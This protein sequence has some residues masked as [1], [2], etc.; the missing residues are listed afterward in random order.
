[1]IKT[2]T[3]ALKLNPIDELHHKAMELAD[4]AYYAKR[5]H[6]D[7][8]TAQTAYQEAFRY[9]EAAAML[10]VN[11]YEYEPSRSVL[12]RSAASLL[13]QLPK[14]TLE[15]YKNIE[16]MAAYGLAGKPNPAIANELREVLETI[17]NAPYAVLFPSENPTLFEKEGSFT[18]IN[19]KTKQF[20]FLTSEEEVI[21]GSFG[22]KVEIQ[23][24]GL[25]GGYRISGE[26]HGIDGREYGMVLKMEIV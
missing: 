6:N 5:R 22:E 25:G 24:L 1:M 2:K 9:E 20:E 8:E 23:G 16:R 3:K 4:K 26:M 13:L 15:D 12:F 18:A 19:I 14:P 11:N 17:Y 7:L 10:L 21:K